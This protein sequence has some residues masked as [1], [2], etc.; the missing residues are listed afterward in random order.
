MSSSPGEGLRFPWSRSE[1]PVARRVVRPL[2]EFLETEAAGGILLL[3]AAAAALVWANS[4]VRSSYEQVWETT[5]ALRVGRWGITETLR[6]WVNDGLLP[7]FFFVVGMEIKRELVHGDL[8]HPRS[9]MLPV[10]AAVGGMLVPALIYLALNTGGTA[11]R[12]W[13]VPM[14]TD[15]AFAVGVLVLVGRGLPPGLKSFLLALAIVDDLGTIVVIAIFYSGGI[16]AA[17]LGV[18]VGLLAVIVLFQQ[19]QVR[20]IVVY[21]LLGVGVWVATFES[22]ISPT[23]AGVALGLLMP[24]VP[25]QLPRAVSLE[26]HRIADFTSDHPVPPDADWPHWLRLAALSREAVSPIG[27]LEPLLHPWTSFLVAP[28]FALANA[29][30]TLDP[31]VLGSALSG[32]VGLGILIGRIA[33]KPLGILGAA[34][35]AARL[36]LAR[37]QPGVRWAHILGVGALAG[38]PFTVAILVAELAFGGRGDVVA[39]KVGVLAAALGAGLLGAAILRA[40]KRP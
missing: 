16:E 24:A 34:W 18:G 3:A 40:V 32:G 37:L 28:L 9:A 12:G 25:F 10:A 13:G 15:I 20:W 21:A 23:I 39:A 6:G 26:A 31:S 8:R 17:A 29:G 14:A 4:P 1:R 7:L 35:L 19:L 30:I 11:A 36:G 33:G 27:R 2:Q 5:L 38:I 22:G